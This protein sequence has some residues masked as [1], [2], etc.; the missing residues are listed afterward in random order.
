MADKASKD[1]SVNKKNKD[2]IFSR[3]TPQHP[4]PDEIRKLARDD[5]VCRYCGVSY[6]I[7]NEIK[8]LEEKLK[9][10]E[11]ELAL[12][13]G[14]EKREELLTQENTLLKQQRVDLQFCVD[15][16]S[17]L[18][19]SL[20]TE[21]ESLKEKNRKS[22]ESVASYKKKYM[23]SLRQ[24]SNL[25]QTVRQQRQ[26]LQEIRE[27]LTSSQSDISENMQSC[28]HSVKEIC[29]LAKQETSALESNIHCL[30]M[31]KVVLAES[32]KKLANTL[33]EKD[34]QLH[35]A[36]VKLQGQNEELCKLENRLHNFDELSNS[37]KNT[38]TVL[39][40]TKK[41]LEE[42]QAQCRVLTVELDQYKM[43]MRN[44]TAELSN[45]MSMKTQQEHT[46]EIALQKLSLEMKAKEQELAS[47][48]KQLKTLESQC[49]DYQKNENE[50]VQQ[51]RL[52]LNEI[53]ELREALLRAKS[54]NEALKV[55]REMM[56]EAHQNRIEDLRDSFK[57]KI[58]EADT[59]P[60][61]L[62]AEVLAEKSRHLAEMKAL[63][64]GLK[65]NFV[66]E[67]QIEKDKYNEL[68]K[69]FQ[70][71]EKDKNNL[72]ETQQVLLEQKYIQ[73]IEEFQRQIG[74]IKK[75]GQE[76]ENELEKEITSLKKIISDLQDRLARLDGADSSKLTEMKSELSKTRQELSDVL[77]NMSLLEGKLKEATTE[78]E[79]L[80]KVVRKECEERY[81]LTEALS[82]ARKELLELKKPLGGYSSA[83]RRSSMTISNSANQILPSPPQGA[84][85]LEDA[86]LKLQSPL[87]TN[88]ISLS[89]S[90]QMSRKNSGSS[91]SSEKQNDAE[92]MK[93]RMR[94][95]SIM[96][97]QS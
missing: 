90:G 30:D 77:N 49:Q 92:I 64:D 89:Y 44:K 8:I 52:G 16:N 2:E 87:S 61:K 53:Q 60:E 97:R 55:E 41:D 83:Q 15:T 24:F 28:L 18:L 31:E 38:E 26:S 20:N 37:L 47:C 13:R 5:T 27:K 88:N 79:F 3:Y 80:Q 22:E 68:L 21:V 43:Q 6:L 32:N 85:T 67:L 65:H 70:A 39:N 54:D 34:A 46:H 58:A 10:A 50:A 96:G 62:Q 29:E 25:S 45:I 12:F 40:G 56:I 51:S 17:K 63:E 1:G 74:D 76:R 33:K 91:L 59:W 48:M 35:Q 57:S 93:N 11:K 78:N 73:K 71:Q 94:I 95:A 81:E 84:A 86:P 19:S 36:D 69:K 82:E 42:S 66:L 4:L 14:Q 7:H 75:K 72:R 9:D 23:A